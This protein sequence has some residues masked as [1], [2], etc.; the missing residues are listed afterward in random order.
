MYTYFNMNE[1]LR[2]QFED[3]LTYLPAINQQALRSFDWAT[4]L[5]AI[6]KN[7]GLHIDELDDLQ[8]ETMLVLV[9]LVDSDQYQNELIN[10]LAISPTEAGKIIE[11]INK[12]V[13]TPIHDY[14][15]SGGQKAESTPTTIMESAGFQM[16]TED[17]PVPSANTVPL[18]RTGGDTPLAQSL[19]ES[20]PV[21]PMPVIPPSPLQFHPTEEK[22]TEPTPIAEMPVTTPIAPVPSIP[23]SKE[24]LEQVY[25]ERQKA[26]DTTLQSMDPVPV[27]PPVS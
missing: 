9:G 24:K 19:P 3:Q 21:V 17:A 13:F 14:I 6:G 10:R 8:I 25:Q 7:Y 15:V 1:K 18:V 22:S 5:V 27:P 26:I 11:D 2:Q 4:E 23:F 20:K 12:R 16:T